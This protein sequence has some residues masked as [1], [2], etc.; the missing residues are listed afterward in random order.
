[1]CLEIYY[2]T[3]QQYVAGHGSKISIAYMLSKVFMYLRSA[4][5]Q[6]VDV[7]QSLNR[8]V[9]TFPGVFSKG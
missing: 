3:T 1:M 2:Y 5:Y 7:P 4:N 8:S 6:V 9:A